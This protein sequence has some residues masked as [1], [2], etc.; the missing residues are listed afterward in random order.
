MEE[1]QFEEGLSVSISTSYSV[2]V[3]SFD[4]EG[5][6]SW[7]GRGP[8]ELFNLLVMGSSSQMLFEMGF[9]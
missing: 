7:K 8:K 5:S 2:G 9:M 6:K 4:Y 3:Y 1:R